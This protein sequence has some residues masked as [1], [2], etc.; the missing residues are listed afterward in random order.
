MTWEDAGQDA[1]WRAGV[2]PQVAFL[3]IARRS[4]SPP[5]QCTEVIVC[6][7]MLASSYDSSCWPAA[8]IRDAR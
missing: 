5:L 6:G 4:C 2:V 3:I 8:A 7:G 1:G